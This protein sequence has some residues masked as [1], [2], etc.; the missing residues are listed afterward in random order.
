MKKSIYRVV[1]NLLLGGWG[2]NYKLYAVFCFITF[3]FISFQIYL[4]DLLTL[5]V[6]KIGYSEDI[7]VV[8][9]IKTNTYREAMEDE[10]FI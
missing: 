3:F 9:R 10:V 6:F 1:H 4:G 7:R 5:M 8:V 2:Q